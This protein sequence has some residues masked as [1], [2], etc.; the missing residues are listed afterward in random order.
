MPSARLAAA[1]RW[2]PQ[3]IGQCEVTDVHRSPVVLVYCA[4]LERRKA[5][6]RRVLKFPSPHIKSPRSGRPPSR[7]PDEGT[8]HYNCLREI[9]IEPIGGTMAMRFAAGGGRTL[10]HAFAMWTTRDCSSACF[11]RSTDQGRS[12]SPPVKLEKGHFTAHDNF[13]MPGHSR[14]NSTARAGPRNLP[15]RPILCGTFHRRAVRSAGRT[16]TAH[17]LAATSVGGVARGKHELRSPGILTYPSMAKDRRK[18][19]T[20]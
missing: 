4:V 12:Q 1:Y 15:Y 10:V 20:Q 9:V 16:R 5:G 3:R 14:S 2:M 6:R 8:A 18:R 11:H 13:A 17:S 19:K 7:L